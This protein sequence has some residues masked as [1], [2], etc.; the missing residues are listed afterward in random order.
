M[1]RIRIQWN[2]NA[3]YQVRSQPAVVAREENLARGVAE[4]SNRAAGIDD[5]YRVSSRQ[6]ARRPQGR[7]R[8]TVITA[9]L[10]AMRDNAKHNRLVKELGNG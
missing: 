7:W 8:T 1:A 10:R 6:G 9:N 2:R 3:L 5:G 4:R